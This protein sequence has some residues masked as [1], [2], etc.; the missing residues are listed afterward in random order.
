MSAKPSER[1]P[2]AEPRPVGGADPGMV[3]PV[4]GFIAYKHVA[5]CLLVAQ[6]VGGILAL[7]VSRTL[8]AGDV[9]YLNTTAVFVSEVIKLLGSLFLMLYELEW[10]ILLVW[11]DL[12]AHVWNKPSETLKVGIPALLY[13]VQNNLLFVALSNMS[14]ATY[15]V[16]YQLKILSTAILSV[17]ILRRFLGAD[18]WASLIM[19]TIGVALIQIPTDPSSAPVS[20]HGG[21]PFIGT[22]AVLCAC[23]TSGFAGV[24]FEKILKGSQISIWMRNFQLALLGC[25]ITL[26][27]ALYNDG[28]AIAEDGF[29]Q[30]YNATT[31]M[32]ILSQSAG[33]LIVAA[34]LK[35]ADNI[36]KCFGNA[37]A[38]VMSCLVSYYYLGDYHPS[39]FFLLGTIL[40]V[41]ATYTYGVSAPLLSSFFTRKAD[42]RR[43]SEDL[44][45]NL[46]GKRVEELI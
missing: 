22:V 42:A 8:G 44:G 31:W 20:T 29:F 4:L 10:K 36:L 18:K 16:T 9:K 37:I 39:V 40:V 15:Q 35:F 7:R 33:G 46:K 45:L 34:V 27:G 1:D 43:A 30:G 3:V 6:T 25:L 32:A 28:E 12:R 41:S 14:P 5:L 26:L 24:Y 38:I 17:I 21:N 2:P 23:L 13:A 19:L 11:H